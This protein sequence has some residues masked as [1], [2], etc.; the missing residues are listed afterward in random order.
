MAGC[1]VI[2][3]AG[4]PLCVKCSV[5]VP[6]RGASGWPEMKP[7]IGVIIRG[8]AAFQHVVGFQA[9]AELND[10]CPDDVQ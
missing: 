8:E 9:V 2:L 6:V 10:G 1:G 7:I 4:M 5:P 3:R